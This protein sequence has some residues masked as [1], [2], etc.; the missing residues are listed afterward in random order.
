MEPEKSYQGII[1]LNQRGQFVEPKKSYHGIINLEMRGWYNMEPM[2]SYQ[3]IINLEL[4][5][6]VCGIKAKLSRNNKLWI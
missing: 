3:G 6:T 1:T 4:K 2:Q 5:R